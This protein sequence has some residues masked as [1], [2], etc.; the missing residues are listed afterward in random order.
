M[1][2]GKI[3]SEERIPPETRA[4]ALR[5]LEEKVNAVNAVPS[6]PAMGGEG[7][8]EVR[9]DGC[10]GSAGANGRRKT[11]VRMPDDYA[12]YA[13]AKPAS[14]VLQTQPDSLYQDENILKSGNL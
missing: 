5:E 10:E 8:I 2:D 9:T 12:T 6:A 1:R 14:D 3:A 13:F 7:E 4:Q 11:E